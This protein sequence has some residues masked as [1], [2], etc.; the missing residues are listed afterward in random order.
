MSPAS[1]SANISKLRQEVLLFDSKNRLLSF[2]SKDEFQSPLVME[3]GD[4]FFEKWLQSKGPLPLDSFFPVN[5]NYTAQQKLSQI[6]AFSTVLREKMEDF[7]QSDLYLV[8]GFLKWDGNALAPSLLVPVDIDITKKTLTLSSKP[9]IENVVLR[10]RLKDVLPNPLPKAD[11]AIINGQFSI[12]LYFSLFEK[13]VATARNWKFTRHGLC[14]SFFNTGDLHMRQW[15]DETPQDKKLDA[16]PNL[17][18][19]FT[20]N[21]FDLQESLFEDG[22]INQMFSPADYHFPYVMDSHTSKVTLDALNEECKAYAINALPGTAKMKV[23]TNIVAENVSKGKKVLVVHRRAVTA[24]NFKNTWKPPFRTFPDSDRAKLQQ[25]LKKFR[26]ELVEYYTTV[27]KPIQPAGI[28]LGDLLTEFGKVKVSKQ[29]IPESV[30]QGIN[31]LDYPTFQNLKADLLELVDLYFEK[32][33]FEARRAFQDVHVPSLDDKQK[34]SLANDL[35]EAAGKVS[36][37]D[38]IITLMESAGLFPTGIFLSSLADL[39]KLIQENFDE[40]TPAFEDWVLRSSNWDSYKETLLALPE[41]GDKWVRYRRQTSEIY[42]D[43]AVDENILSAREDFAESQ[44]TTL[45]GL[46]DRYRSSRRTLMKV[47]RNPKSVDSDLKLLDLIDT[48]LDLQEN[49]RAYKETSVLGNHLLG[50]DWMYERSDWVELNRK[51]HYIYDFKEKNKHN[52]KMDLLLQILEQWHIFRD[53]QPEIARFYQA[54]LDLEKSIKKISR[55]MGLETSLE[56][57]SIEKWLDTIKSWS[58][59]W[60]NL[61]I[62]LQ[63]TKLIAKLSRYNCP[64]LVKFV[65]DTNNVSKEV[66][67]AVIHYWTGFQIQQAT[68][69]C[70]DLFSLNPKA[71]SKK[72]KSYQSLLD[73]FSNANFREF[74]TA[75]ENDN[76]LLTVIHLNDS[77]HLGHKHF[78]LAILLDADCI[79]AVE[80]LPTLLATDRIILMG[81]PQSPALEHLPFDAYQDAGTNHTAMF[82]ESIL[83]SALRRGIPNRE[84]WFSCNYANPA[85]VDFANKHIYNKGIKQLPLPN[86]ED[87]KGI[88]FK[89]VQNKVLAIAQAAIRHAERN[90]GK[91]LGIVAFHQSTCHEIESAIKAMLIADTP[92]ARFF[93][94]QNLDIRY[95]VKTPE[96]AVDRYRDVVL[97]CAESDGAIGIAG[98]H[99]ISVCTSLAKTEQYVFISESDL[100]KKANSKHSSL[101]WEWIS[102]L[103]Q[104]D[105]TGDY[106]HT[107]ASSVIRSQVIS[108]LQD[109]NIQLEETFNSAGIAVGPVIV[110]A[111]NNKRF[112]ALIEDD[113]TT[114]RFRSSIED[115]DYI[116]PTLLKQLGWK[117]LNL[118]LPFWYMSRQDEV[119]HLIAT[120][121]I[122]Q[123]VAPPP[124][125]PQ[126]E[127]Q[128]DEELF[129][130]SSSGGIV[131]PY[132]VQHPK[133]EG[134]PHDKPIAELPAAALITQLKFY[135]D[136]EAPIHQEI[137][138]N[139]VL[140][141]HHVDRAGPMIQQA[142]TEAINQGLQKKRFVKTGLFFYSLNPVEYVPRD[143]SGRPE[144]E[145]KLAYVGP[146]ERAL[147]P[148]S[149][150]EHALKQALGLLE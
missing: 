149:M 108:T 115:R 2:S 26:Q 105:F 40:N 34:L 46:S 15:F 21:G 150:D 72:S 121:A 83:A 77:Y 117:V 23:A 65:E 118:W 31:Q 48:L 14:L 38:T 86:R 36:E 116:R 95:Y 101:F 99:K 8:L 53:L 54:V 63:L 129:S 114:E 1:S 144:S 45:K 62:H 111:N 32:K 75:V 128:N 17:N 13:A 24:S 69:S 147:M 120:I 42:T 134:T 81:D 59:N 127:E 11:D 143:R 125:D 19:L 47:I 44:N 74:Q 130:E 139:R 145:R 109:E 5:A 140:E 146:E 43:D 119:G 89:A 55:D 107:P 138:I 91:T 71:R 88:R 58:E 87:F 29:K 66:A 79:S 61:D 56:S 50:K 22:D 27:N 92:A 3:A 49:K 76:S 100:S 4:L 68:K 12:L 132:Q 84:L 33:G 30:F 80:A 102:Y 142:L 98:D 51:I 52:P 133:I 131:V 9:P 57:L 96:R 136:H 93:T 148:D 39:L 113:C 122:E 6:D 18:A 67:Q 82:H 106:H 25:E 104:R 28:M 135:V 37:L 20:Q 94:Q 112:L 85:L 78:D 141:L 97:V 124:P 110:D 126:E 137:L 123:S 60:E 73:S 35:T 70:P 10:E 7:G 90:P 64:G 103:Q 41:A 16:N